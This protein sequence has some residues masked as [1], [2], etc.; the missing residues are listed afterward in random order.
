MPSATYAIFRTAIL[1]QK[2]VHCVYD[3]QARALC[4]VILGHSNGEEMVLAYQ[5]GGG[6]RGRPLPPGGEWKCLRLTKV[7]DARLSEGRWREG[8]RHG[9]AQTCVQ[10]IDLDINVHVRKRR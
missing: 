6:T 9:R 1:T 5:V 7:E 2:Q 8:E 3:G 4:P 10:D